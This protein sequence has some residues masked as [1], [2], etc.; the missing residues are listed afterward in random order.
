LRRGGV[1][2]ISLGESSQGARAMTESGP[3][4]IGVITVSILTPLVLVVG[5]LNERA[6]LLHDILIGTVVINNPVHAQVLR[7]RHRGRGIILK[8]RQGI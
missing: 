6:R 1:F 5:L 2:S 7:M 8:W 3:G 4:R